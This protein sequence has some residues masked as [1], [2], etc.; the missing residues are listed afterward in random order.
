MKVTFTEILVLINF[1]I[2]TN[3]F[4]LNNSIGRQT[5]TLGILKK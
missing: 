2:F 1:Q 5:E 4:F 3:F